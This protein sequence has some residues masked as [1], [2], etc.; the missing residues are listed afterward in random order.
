[1]TRAYLTILFLLIVAFSI[2]QDIPDPMSPPRLVNDF[3][4][5][6]SKQEL[7]SLENKLR[8]YHDSTSTQIAVVTV[9]N[10]KGYDV[11]D[12]AFRIGE[13]WGIG[14]KGKNNG[15]VVL[16]AIDDHKA[17]IATGYGMEGSIT[18]VATR[19]IRESYMNPNFKA[20]N[21]YKGLDEA[22]TA[23][24]KL[25][26]G[27]FTADDFQPTPRG[28]GFF[29]LFVFLFIIIITILAAVSRTR[30]NHFGKKGLDFWT[31]LWLTSLL[32]GGRNRGGNGWGGGGGF[33]GGG[34]GGGGF[35]GFGGG[36]FGGGG[37]GGSW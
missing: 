18:D 19:R 27:E 2:A 20:G 7:S 8:A 23:L 35:G 13:K 16:V 22:T 32:G 9:Q 26:S 17:A 29:A 3:A 21:F 31:A 14:Q 10:L 15:L 6:L 34:S 37:S 12:F 36:G 28:G 24:M 4:N 11:L 30:K 5:V 1:M 25:A 33:G